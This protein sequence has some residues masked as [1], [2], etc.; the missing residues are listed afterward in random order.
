M[1]IRQ[2]RVENLK[3]LGAFTPDFTHRG[4]PRMWT[5]MIGENGTAKTTLLQSIALA[6]AGYK[7]VSG[8]AGAAVKHL[9]D[10]RGKE[11]MSIGATFA[12]G[13]MSLKGGQVHPPARAAPGRAQ[14]GGVV[15]AF[16]RTPR[17]GLDVA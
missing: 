10:R 6:A 5:V 11:R 9:R 17:G 12:F 7:E 15:A 1:Y 2:L 13:P 16:P 3:R 8:L 4:E 14:A